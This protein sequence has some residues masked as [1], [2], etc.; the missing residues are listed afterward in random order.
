MH[1]V[2]IPRP[3]KVQVVRHHPPPHPPSLPLHFAFLYLFDV[4]LFSQK[5]K[6][7]EKTRKKKKKNQKKVC[8][9]NNKKAQKHLKTAE[10]TQPPSPS[11]PPRPSPLLSFPLHHGPR[12]IYLHSVVG[13]VG[14]LCSPSPANTHQ[15]Q[16]KKK[17]L[18]SHTKK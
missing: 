13:T 3:L 6:K 18:K 15:D 14:T 1:R 10:K 5:E 8:T 12:T 17:H 4:D 11:F 2:C 9:K 16:K 7:E